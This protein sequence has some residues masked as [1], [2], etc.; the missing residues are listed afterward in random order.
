MD[1]GVEDLEDVDKKLTSLKVQLGL[2]IA[3]CVVGN[4]II[5]GLVM[6]VRSSGGSYSSPEYSIA[7]I[8]ATILVFP[9]LFLIRYLALQIR[10][11]KREARYTSRR[12][13]DDYVPRRSMGSYDLP[14]GPL[15][16]SPAEGAVVVGVCELCKKPVSK[17]NEHFQCRHCDYLI[18]WKHLSAF[19]KGQNQCPRCRTPLQ[20]LSV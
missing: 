13:D 1:N 16:P 4:I 19:L 3:A 8:I 14:P 9:E 11:Y 7:F 15:P 10:K 5:I 20:Y 6:F 12:L 2:V 17:F 18:H